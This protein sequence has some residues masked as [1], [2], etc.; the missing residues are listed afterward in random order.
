MRYSVPKRGF[1]LIELLVV[2]AI[3]AILAAMLL[4]ALNQAKAK[5]LSISC[6]NLLKQMNHC[7]QFYAQDNDG[8]LT[9]CMWYVHD[10]RGDQWYCKLQPYAPALFKRKEL[11]AKAN[12]YCPGGAAEMGMEFPHY[13]NGFVMK[14]EDFNAGGYTHNRDSGYFSWT[15][16]YNPAFRQSRMIN[17]THKMAIADGYYYEL[18][19]SFESWDPSFGVMA[20]SRH[21]G[22]GHAHTLFYDGH[23]GVIPRAS[24]N[25]TFG[26]QTALVYYTELDR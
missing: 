20:W 23:A 12:P 17:T 7:E 15:G 14:E 4:P 1:T 13:Y 2:I 18:G 3:I 11:T 8:M 19:R 22:I 10:P 25:A 26:N 5:A 24:S 16:L 21:G 6:V 9:P